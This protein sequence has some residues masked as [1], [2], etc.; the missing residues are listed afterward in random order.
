LKK[1]TALLCFAF[2]NLNMLHTFNLEEINYESLRKSPYTDHVE[3]FG[4][5]FNAVSIE[6]MIEFGLG[7]GTKFFL[8]R[9]PKLT[10]VEIVNQD[11]SDAWYLNCCELY[12]CYTH[13]TPVLVRGSAYLTQANILAMQSKNP[14]LYDK[15]YLLEIKEL[16]LT[17]TG[18]KYDLAFVDPGIHNRGDI[19]ECL[20]NR[21]DIIAAHD[22]NSVPEIYGWNRIVMPGNYQKISFTKGVGLTFWVNKERKD[23]INALLKI[24]K[25][26]SK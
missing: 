18:K 1:I 7:L 23:V 22:T 17:Y 25:R 10:S 19:V 13:W 12:K 11:Q 26:Q 9:I 15:N 2:L 16:V 20:F 24:K 6:N 3:V 21:V 8:E 5:L 4:R 14:S